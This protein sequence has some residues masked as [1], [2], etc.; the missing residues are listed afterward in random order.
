MSCFAKLAKVIYTINT[1]GDGTAGNPV[2]E[3]ERYWTLD[4][5]LIATIDPFVASQQEL[6]Q[7]L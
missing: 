1:E 4:G 2:R 7:A 6:S 5:R 3:V